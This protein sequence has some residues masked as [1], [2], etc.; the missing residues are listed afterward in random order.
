MG[1]NYLDI[2]VIPIADMGETMQRKGKSDQRPQ[3]QGFRGYLVL[4][5]DMGHGITQRLDNPVRSLPEDA[6]PR[7][8]YRQ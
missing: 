8:P 7:Q 6:L 5:V 1:S 3:E 4:Y 2:S